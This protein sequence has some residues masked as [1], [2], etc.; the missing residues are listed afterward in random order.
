MMDPQLKFEIQKVEFDYIERKLKEKKRNA[1]LCTWAFYL[2]GRPNWA[3]HTPRSP[4]FPHAA[5]T[6]VAIAWAPRIIPSSL[7][8]LARAHW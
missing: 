5:L 7:A 8:L 3:L 6:R 4:T 1:H 2:L